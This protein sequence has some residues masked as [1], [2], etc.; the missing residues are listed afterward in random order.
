MALA[1]KDLACSQESRRRT[2]DASA[3]KRLCMTPSLGRHLHRPYDA[4]EALSLIIA[5]KTWTILAGR[6]VWAALRP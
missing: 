4:M 2:R 3:L 5:Q 1:M 6:S